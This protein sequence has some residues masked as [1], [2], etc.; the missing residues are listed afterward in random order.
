MVVCPFSTK[1]SNILGCTVRDRR[2]AGL[3]SLVGQVVLHTHRDG[4]GLHLL[5]GHDAAQRHAAQVL[6]TGDGAR[7][8]P[9]VHTAITRPTDREM[10][11]EG[12]NDTVKSQGR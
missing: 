2:R 9:K 4:E 8:R 7:A 5:R 11:V 1:E 3:D 6:E 10:E 12:I